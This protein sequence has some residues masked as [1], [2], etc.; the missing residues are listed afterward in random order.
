MGANSV[1]SVWVIAILLSGCLGTASEDSRIPKDAISPVRE[2]TCNEDHLVILLPAV[3]YDVPE[4][5]EENGFYTASWY[6]FHCGE[7]VR[8]LMG[9]ELEAPHGEH[10]RQL[11]HE[12]GFQASNCKVSRDFAL[13]GPVHIAQHRATLVEEHILTYKVPTSEGFFPGYTSVWEGNEQA[14]VTVHGG[15]EEIGAGTYTITPI[16]FEHVGFVTP[17]ENP[18]HLVGNVT[19]QW[20]IKNT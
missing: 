1:K 13:D 15:G 2:D 17:P 20:Y 10:R 5:I 9:I 14:I 4:A 19:T 12:C 18:I 7:V 11:L 6:R 3:L 16:P 8:E